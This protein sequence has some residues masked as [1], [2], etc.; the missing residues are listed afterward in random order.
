MGL[1]VAQG[2]GDLHPTGG[3]AAVTY[4]Q[5]DMEATSCSHGPH[6]SMTLPLSQV[7]SANGVDDSRDNVDVIVI[8]AGLAGLCAAVALH[9]AGKKVLVFEAASRV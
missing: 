3:L 1:S 9:E 6:Q 7:I 4:L 5:E 2:T 8:G